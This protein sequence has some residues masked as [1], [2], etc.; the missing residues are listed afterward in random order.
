[1]E[2]CNK[3]LKRDHNHIEMNRRTWLY[4]RAGQACCSLTKRCFWEYSRRQ[5]CAAEE[6]VKPIQKN[7]SRDDLCYNQVSR[8]W[9]FDLFKINANSN[10]WN[11]IVLLKRSLN[12]HKTEK[13]EP[14]RRNL[15]GHA[16]PMHFLSHLYFC[17]E[18]S[19]CRDR[20]I[21]HQFR[22]IHDIRNTAESVQE[23]QILFH[24]SLPPSERFVTKGIFGLD[25]FINDN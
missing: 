18:K 10:R 6:K 3:S 8:T 23:T 24:L 12:D 16:S 4:L 2:D 5:E 17:I 13:V 22:H 7:L 21:F 15:N 11:F 1:M 9:N 19:S 20:N 25:D 14:S